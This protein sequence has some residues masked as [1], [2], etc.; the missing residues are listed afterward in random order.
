MNTLNDFYGFSA[1]PFSK[2]I[3]GTDLFPSRGHLEIQGRLTFALQERLPALITGDV[4]TGKSTALRA[5]THSLDRNIRPGR[6]PVISASFNTA[7]PATNTCTAP[8]ILVRIL[9]SRLVDDGVRVQYGD[10]GDGARLD[11]AAIGKPDAIG[12]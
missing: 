2:S 10:I 3:P 6:A 12:R 7:T 9:E 11:A 8:C 4:G 1:T 5:F